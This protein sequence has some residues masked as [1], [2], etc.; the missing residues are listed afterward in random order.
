M[1]SEKE[2]TWVST[3]PWCSSRFSFTEF[4]V[5]ADISSKSANYCHA[6]SSGQTGLLL[7]CEAELGDPMLEFEFG[8]D[9]GAAEIAKERG[10]I[11]TW[12]KGA[13]GPRGWKDAS[14]VHENLAG[15]LVVGA[16]PKVIEPF[17]D[18]SL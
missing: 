9:T 1:L 14:C 3:P 12:G 10:C 2:Y 13:T 16:L 18:H 11:A 15:V 4:R 7:L 17:T 8:G 6:D 5:P